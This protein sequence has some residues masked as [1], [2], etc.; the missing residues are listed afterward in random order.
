MAI[1][2]ESAKR[3]VAR[4]RTPTL[5]A[6][7]RM[8]RESQE[9][10]QNPYAAPQTIELVLPLAHQQSPKSLA[11]QKE[12][13]SLG[14]LGKAAIVCYIVAFF[15]PVAPWLDREDAWNWG[16][17]F[18]IFGW[19]LKLCWHPVCFSWW[20][21]VFF[22]VAITKWK[23]NRMTAAELL[24]LLAAVFATGFL[25]V[26]QLE[27]NWRWPLPFGLW[28][29]SMYVLMLGIFRANNHQKELSVAPET[30]G[31]QDANQ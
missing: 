3:N 15:V 16:A 9:T 5:I 12:S 27:D 7:Q 24:A 2:P 8:A 1:Q 17:G 18:G 22:W 30:W 14:F 29:A 13:Q 21:N 19:G 28:C 25:L 6:Q 31:R 20:A 26:M 11:R 10:C 4:L 23:C